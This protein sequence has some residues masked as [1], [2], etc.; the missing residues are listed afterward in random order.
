MKEEEKRRSAIC[1]GFR[2]GAFACR[3]TSGQAEKATAQLKD[4]MLEV[5]SRKVRRRVSGP[6]QRIAS[7]HHGAEALHRRMGH[8]LKATPLIG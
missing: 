6:H 8:S 5:A 7:A 2:Y 4:G 1:V 3:A